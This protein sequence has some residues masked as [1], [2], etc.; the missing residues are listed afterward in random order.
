MM[1]VGTNGQKSNEIRISVVRDLSEYMK[2]VAI[3][4][5]VF[6]A[7]QDCPYD[8]EYDG[9]DLCSTHLIAYLRGEPV[10][11]LRLRYFAGFAKIERVCVMKSVRGGAVVRALIDTSVEIVSRKGYRHVIG[12]IQKRL[13]PFWKQL[14]FIARPERDGFRFSDYDYVECERVL[15]ARHD[16]LT[17]DSDP[18][19]VMRP[20]GA[21]DHENVLDHSA[22]R[23]AV[24]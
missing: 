11:T 4:S 10:A 2:V 3:R 17:R 7:E 16:A 8:E 20:E 13:V 23:P 5:A 21:W 1:S 14:G 15:D 9:N 12:Y 18:F 19:V 24:A 6:L 22:K